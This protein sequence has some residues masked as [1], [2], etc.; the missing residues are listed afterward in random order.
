MMRAKSLESIYS[1][2][3]GSHLKYILFFYY[4]SILLNLS[5]LSTLQNFNGI[6]YESSIRHVWRRIMGTQ[7]DLILFTCC[8]SNYYMFQIV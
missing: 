2:W 7:G 3:N 6:V 1:W 4:Y 5:K 8:S